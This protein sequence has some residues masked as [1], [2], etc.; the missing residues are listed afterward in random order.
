M[1]NS[2]EFKLQLA[3]FAS[4]FTQNDASCWH[5]MHGVGGYCALTVYSGIQA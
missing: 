1:S 4:W 5:L 3:F 2:D